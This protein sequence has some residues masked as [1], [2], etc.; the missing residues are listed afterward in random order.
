VVAQALD[1]VSAIST[2]T[3]ADLQREVSAAT[4]K[5]INA[6]FEV[7]QT[8]VGGRLKE[9]EFI[10]A[11]SRSLREGRFLILIAGDGIREGVQSLTAL[12]DRQ[13]TKAFKFAL[14]EVAIFRFGGNRLAIQ[15]RV[16]AETETIKRQITVLNLKGIGNQVTELIV[17][18]DDDDTGEDQELKIQRK[19]AWA[20]RNES[21]PAWWQPV[22]AM[23]F[24]DPEQEAPRYAAAPKNAIVNTPFAGV[25]IKAYAS[26][27][28][29]DTG[30]FLSGR[31]TIVA[32]IRPFVTRE[33]DALIEELPDGT[34]IKADNRYPIIIEKSDLGS[35]DER[36]AWIIKTINAFA[37]VL[38]PR[39]RRWYD[40]VQQSGAGEQPR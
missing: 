20:E 21:L 4:G 35:D 3:Y 19:Q 27:N 7:V 5:K 40:E 9:Q 33:Q 28:S 14:V 25:R 15:P 17:N 39:L 23:K 13:A 32:L 31:Q 29:S 38:R 6:P 36:R 8:S 30:V 34:V 37:N 22:L 26:V 12:V 2:W 11:V 24:D 16:L 1:Y 18:D 10:D